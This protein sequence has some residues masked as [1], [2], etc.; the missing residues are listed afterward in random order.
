MIDLAKQLRTG[1]RQRKTPRMF[2]HTVRQCVS[3]PRALYHI[4]CS[5][6]YT[7]LGPRFFIVFSG[8]LM[9]LSFFYGQAVDKYRSCAFILCTLL[10]VNKLLS[11]C[12]VS[13]TSN[14]DHI[15]HTV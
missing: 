5:L 10:S 12:F 6:L 8:Y 4:S 11:L 1:S 3:A 9:K 13:N 14:N 7:N 15:F 2:D